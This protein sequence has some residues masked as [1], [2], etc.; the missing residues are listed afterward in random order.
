[1]RERMQRECVGKKGC[2]V[3]E[4]VYVCVQE[5]ERERE[6]VGEIDKEDIVCL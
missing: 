5:R 4:R 2:S 6:R 3:C 1:M